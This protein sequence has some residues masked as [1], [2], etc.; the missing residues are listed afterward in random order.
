[1]EQ[2]P[3]FVYVIWLAY[4]ACPS[5]FIDQFHTLQVFSDN[6]VTILRFENFGHTGF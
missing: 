4:S 5:L 1:M 2:G 6:Q 3:R